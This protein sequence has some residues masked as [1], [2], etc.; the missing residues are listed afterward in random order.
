MSL[1]V[2]LSNALSGLQVNQNALQVTSTNIANL[3]TDGYSRKVHNQETRVLAGQG[4]GVETS[5]ITRQVDNFLVADFAKQTSETEAARI[6]SRFFN[7]IQETFGSVGNN[8]ALNNTITNLGVA[9][10]NLANAPEVAAQRFTAV[11]QA[12]TL[13]EHIKDTAQT[14]QD[15]RSQTD[16][17]I[18]AGVEIINGHLQA[19]ADLNQSI[20]RNIAQNTPTGDLE[21]QRDR[22]L[23]EIAEFLDVQSFI[24][25]ENHMQVI[26]RSGRSLVSS[27]VAS[28]L[29]YTPSPGMT[30][31]QT[32]PTNIGG[33]HVNANG[34]PTAL[35][36]ITTSIRGGRLATLIEMRDTTLPSV[37]DQLDVLAASLRDTLNQVHNRGANTLIGSGTGALDAAA[38]YGTR[39]ITA[40]GDHLT[41]SNDVTL[42]ILDDSGQ[43]ATTPL[44]ISAGATTPETIRGQIDAY[45]DSG[46]DFGE[47]AWVDDRLEI[48]LEPGYRLAIQDNGP[49]ADQ[50]DVTVTFDA[51]GDTATETYLGFSNF[52]GLNDFYQTPNLSGNGFALENQGNQL[53]I[54]STIVVREDIVTNPEAL[55]RGQLRGTPPDLQLGLGDSSIAQDLAAA[56]TESIDFPSV[57]NGPSNVSTTLAGYAGTILSFNAANAAEAENALEFQD[58]SLEV[59]RNKVQSQSGVNLDEELSN[60]VI[61]Q[62]AYNASARVIQT[63]NELLD[64]LLSL[65]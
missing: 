12:V 5:E 4:S 61:L 6:R 48:K 37:T 56:F 57:T 19:I 53:G 52:F 26:T 39:E 64:T 2:T 36:D 38:L 46:I 43:A 58:F 51:D 16:I 18:S 25:S 34:N 45:L 62:N 44:T 28:E 65:R 3:N 63:A 13:T 40:P 23:K 15:L 31:A 60:M 49:A 29:S 21:D 55:A 54:S 35:N 22:S 14:I 59:L 8:N 17:E 30:P 47:A 20:S 10:E 50:G 27:T 32:Y 41:L 1:A 7:Q 42:Q 33:I 24:N 9:F 11:N